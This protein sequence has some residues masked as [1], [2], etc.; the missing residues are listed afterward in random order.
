MGIFEAVVVFFISWWVVFLP[1]L[2]AGTRSQQDAGSVVPGSE[3]GAP[4]RIS[5]KPKFIIATVG[6]AA[7]TLL[8]WMTLYFGWLSFMI[9]RD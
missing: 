3:A 6:A 9:P 4:E 2:S 1:T 7:I 8:I 5:W